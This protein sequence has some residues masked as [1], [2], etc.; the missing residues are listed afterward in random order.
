MYPAYSIILAN[1]LIECKSFSLFNMYATLIHKA[2]CNLDMNYVDIWCT[3]VHETHNC[4]QMKIWYLGHRLSYQQY[5]VPVTMENYMLF[6]SWHDITCICLV[7]K[8]KKKTWL[9]MN[10][11]KSPVNF[12]WYVHIIYYIYVLCSHDNNCEWFYWISTWFVSIKT[13]KIYSDIT[14]S[15]HLFCLIKFNNTIVNYISSIWNIWGYYYY[16]VLC[17]NRALS[18]TIALGPCPEASVLPAVHCINGV[19]VI[20]QNH[21]MDCSQIWHTPWEC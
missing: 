7:K 5:M 10:L 17:W 9:A 6:H 2:S 4:N 18:V 20:T 14:S 1:C 8:K 3:I 12:L 16:M 13:L 11:C 19:S 15:F 21:R